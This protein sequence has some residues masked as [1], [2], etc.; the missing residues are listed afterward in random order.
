MLTNLPIISKYLIYEL[1][2]ADIH[3]W[4]TISGTILVLK[5]YQTETG[6]SLLM[7]DWYM[8]AQISL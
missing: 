8:S 6:V 1:V 5:Q 3:K 4:Q 7:C 2:L